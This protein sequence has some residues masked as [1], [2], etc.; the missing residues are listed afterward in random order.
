MN[1]RLT[2]AIT[3]V[4]LVAAGCSGDGTSDDQFNRIA[5]KLAAKIAEQRDGRASDQVSPEVVI[6][7]LIRVI[8]GRTVTG[9]APAFAD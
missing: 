9:E 7:E 8:S 1:K 6:S 5:E 3:A 4:L 2:T